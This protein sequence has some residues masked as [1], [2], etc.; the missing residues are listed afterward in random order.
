MISVFSNLCYFSPVT[1][2]CQQRY[3]CVPGP[4]RQSRAALY[5][6][7]G[8]SLAGCVQLPPGTGAPPSSF[9]PSAADSRPL[10]IGALI[11]RWHTGIVLP[12]SELG[13]LRPLLHHDPAA[14][15]VS[16]G[17]GNRRFYMSSHPGPGDAIAALFRSPSTL[18][19]QP[20]TSPSRLT[21]S[22]VHILWLCADRE[23]V[24]RVDR[25]IERSLIRPGHP[26][27]LGPGPFP[28][29]RFYASTGHYSAVHT[30]N[31]WTAAALEYAHLPIS[32]AGVLFSA[33]VERRV[34]GLRACP[35]SQ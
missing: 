14:A 22:D 16:F 12:V 30:C 31:T 1:E 15:Y 11:A 25:Y 6:S 17:W 28:D 9:L 3:A 35:A 10:E 23:Q 18:L 8:V 27:D 24:W 33:Q 21:A 26:I 4:R 2:R 29:S 13:P 32:A 34:S 19:V 5:L 20:A 7:I